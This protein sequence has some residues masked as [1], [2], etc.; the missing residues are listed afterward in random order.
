[1]KVNRVRG[2]LAITL[3]CV[4]CGGASSGGSLEKSLT[5]NDSYL[6]MWSVVQSVVS[7]EF[8][9][10]QIPRFWKFETKPGMS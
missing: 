2:I 8:H 3:F 1:M 7:S 4:T 10:R 5:C 9:W 6:R